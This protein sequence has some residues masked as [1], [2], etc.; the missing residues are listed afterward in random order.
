M[1]CSND[2][3]VSK[4]ITESW[5]NETSVDDEDDFGCGVE[6]AKATIVRKDAKLAWIFGG[7]S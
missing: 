1:C 3:L 6:Q 2:E 5:E 4:A 7:Q